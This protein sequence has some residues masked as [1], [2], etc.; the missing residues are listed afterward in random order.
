MQ[1]VDIISAMCTLLMRGGAAG[2]IMIEV[3]VTAAAIA[4][5]ATT[6]DTTT[7]AVAADGGGSNGYVPLIVL[8]VICVLCGFHFSK[9][10]GENGFGY[11][12]AF[13]LPLAYIVVFFSYGF[14]C[15][16]FIYTCGFSCC[17]GRFRPLHIRDLTISKTSET[18]TYADDVL[19]AKQHAQNTDLEKGGAPSPAEVQGRGRSAT[20]LEKASDHEQ[21]RLDDL[22]Q[23]LK[24]QEKE[25][26]ETIAAV[27]SLPPGNTIRKSTEEKIPQLISAL[28]KTRNKIDI[29]T[30][31]IAAIAREAG[32]LRPKFKF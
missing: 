4:S 28:Q 27:N 12:N 23:M 10:G 3:L 19:H 20:L 5:N 11:H 21:S 14:Y 8:A 29:R 7:T 30:A 13:F 17:Q 31:K 6:A 32:A 18:S 24:Q 26:D 16:G 9:K 15:V 2:E 1:D 22:Q 25:L